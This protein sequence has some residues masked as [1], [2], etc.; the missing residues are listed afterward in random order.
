MKYFNPLLGMLL[1]CLIMPQKSLA[2]AVAMP[3]RYAADEAASILRKGGN[4]VDAAVAAAFV[5]AV[6]YPEAGNIGGGGFM[7]ARMEGNAVFLDFRE[8]AP[9]AASRDM[10][11][12]ERGEVIEDLSFIGGL[13]SG[14]P[15]TVA[16]MLEAHR[17]FGSLR[18]ADLLEKAVQL[19]QDGF[20]VPPELA[21]YASASA[22]SFS[23][24]TNFERYYGELRAGEIF[25]Q[26]ELA[27][28]LATIAG[29]PEEFYRGEI[30]G[31]IAAQSQ[32]SGGIITRRDMAEY[33]P[34]WREPLIFEWRGYRLLT[35]PPPS[36]GGV[37]LAQLLGI[38][39]ARSD[40]FKGVS[41]ND[42]DYLH[43]LA[44]IEKRVFADRAEYLGDPASVAVPVADLIAPDYLARRGLELNE[45]SISLA[46]PVVPG[47][48]S[49][50]TTHLSVL[51]DRGNAVSM[52]YTLNWDFGSGVVV[53]GGG[54]LLNNEMDDF[55]VKP[56]VTNVYGVTGSSRNAVAPG[57]RMLSSMTPTILL[58]D[59]KPALLLGSPG[60]STIITSVF[61]V[62][63][64]R[65]HWGMK[66]EEAIAATRFHH[67]LPQ[68]DLIRHDARDIPASTRET[69]AD[70]GYR[71]EPNSW[72]DLGD[73]QAISSDNGRITAVSDPR[74]R[75]KAVVLPPAKP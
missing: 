60:G 7:L 9:A 52:T 62:V 38:F 23:G 34:V 29:R 56:G 17:R 8:T 32:R 73:V 2:A 61:Q 45:K 35:A 1:C 39:D 47:L 46:P 24:R 10:Y 30:A 19:A 59:D 63:L 42:A 3:D 49:H 74:G 33:Q 48:E 53:E 20:E 13:S 64:N 55:S 71:V 57:R 11:L 70:M 6:T 72:G 14:V 50:Q 58:A 22:E 75:G 67:Q 5:L 28:T 68:A 69:L 66:L 15:G 27:R 54:F 21:G 65:L 26:P 41:H 4:A 44:E 36:S 31:L 43:R 25:R 37:A 40:L 12:N 51:D 18:W 16:G